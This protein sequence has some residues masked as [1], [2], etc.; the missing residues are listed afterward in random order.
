M[1]F[2]HISW[3]FIVVVKVDIDV[4]DISYL[5]CCFGMMFLNENLLGSSISTDSG[6]PQS[7]GWLIR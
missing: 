6:C 1:M 2:S 4:V 3:N 7:P 5:T